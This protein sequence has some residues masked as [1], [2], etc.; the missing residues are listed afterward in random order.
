MT[1]SVNDR[2][3]YNITLSILVMMTI[4]FNYFVMEMVMKIGLTLGILS[5]L[6]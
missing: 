5:I 4:T 6:N 2:L 1:G 3:S